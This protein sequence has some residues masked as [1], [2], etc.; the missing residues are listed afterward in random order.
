M[1]YILISFLFSSNPFRNSVKTFKFMNSVGS[2]VEMVM[3][4]NKHLLDNK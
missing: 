1:Q 2:A 3:A 4:N